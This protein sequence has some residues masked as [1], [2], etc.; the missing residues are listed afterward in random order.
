M[1]LWYNDF[2]MILCYDDFMLWWFYVMM[3]L[4]YNDFMLCYNGLIL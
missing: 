1:I 2:M 3:I 4:C